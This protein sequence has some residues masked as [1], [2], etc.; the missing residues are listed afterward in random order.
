[1]QQFWF[2]CREQSGDYRGQFDENNY[3][4][5]AQSTKI[6]VVKRNFAIVLVLNQ[7][8]VK[9]QIIFFCSSAHPMEKPISREFVFET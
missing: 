1:M 5:Y 2:W 8:D 3:L 9:D 6:P 7:H 4:E